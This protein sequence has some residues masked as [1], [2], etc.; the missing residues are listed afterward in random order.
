MASSAWSRRGTQQ[1]GPEIFFF[2]H[3]FDVFL[4]RCFTHIHFGLSTVIYIFNG[5]AEWMVYKEYGKTSVT[6]F[7][8]A[9]MSLV[10]MLL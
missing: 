5:P 7:L 3:G 8:A 6:H 1:T 9:I 4:L 2:N 10:Q